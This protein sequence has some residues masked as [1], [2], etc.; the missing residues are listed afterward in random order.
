MAGKKKQTNLICE[1]ILT[2]M[3]LLVSHLSEHEYTPFALI[4]RVYGLMKNNCLF[5]SIF[6]FI[7]TFFL[8][9]SVVTQRSIRY[10]PRESKTIC[11]YLQIY[12]CMSVCMYVC[13]YGRPICLSICLFIV[14]SVRLSIYLPFLFII[15][16]LLERLPLCPQCPITE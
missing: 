4:Q 11:G 6:W 9:G 12:L 13:M 8:S 1:H 15:V 5:S 16:L 3:L 14:L 2:P 10:S 7:D